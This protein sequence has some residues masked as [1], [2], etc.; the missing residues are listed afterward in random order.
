[1]TE[2]LNTKL[3]QS[4]M[5]NILILDQHVFRKTPITITAN[6]FVILWSL[7]TEGPSS[8]TKLANLLLMSKQQMSPLIEKLYKQKLVKKETSPADR[9]CTII[10]ITPAGKKLIDQHKENLRAYFTQNLY[11]LTEEEKATLLEAMKIINTSLNKMF[12][13]QISE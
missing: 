5:D 3:S 12:P 9:R 7:V 4:F 11:P 13:P 8:I 1:M 2:Q 6:Y 10:T